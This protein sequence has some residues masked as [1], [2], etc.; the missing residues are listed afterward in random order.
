[1]PV[2]SRFV[3]LSDTH[4]VEPGRAAE[5]KTWW[6]RV[7]EK[8][9][10]DIGAALVRSV[11]RLEP[12]F[13]IHCGDLTADPH[14]ANYEFGLEI[15]NQLGCPWYAVPGNQ[16]SSQPIRCEQRTLQIYRGA[17]QQ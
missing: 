7:L 6:N 11:S 17:R 3:V 5:G 1:M 14:L 13:V 4:F 10:A 15:M 16:V 12:D 8:Q 2:S 9:C